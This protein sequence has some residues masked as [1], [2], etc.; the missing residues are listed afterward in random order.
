MAQSVVKEFV[1][2]VSGAAVFMAAH[3]EYLGVPEVCPD[4]LWQTWENGG[5]WQECSDEQLWEISPPAP[6]VGP[7]GG[8]SSTAQPPGQLCF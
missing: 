4:S 7:G 1:T 6:T 5:I 8:Y 3:E 2:I